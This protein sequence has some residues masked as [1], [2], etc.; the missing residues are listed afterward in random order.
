MRTVLLSIRPLFKKQP[1]HVPPTP[2]RLVVIVGGRYY[3]CTDKSI[4]DYNTR[5]SL[6]PGQ[7]IKSQCS[8]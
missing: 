8:L 4:E 5:F 6:H 2:S 7:Y 1:A 3:I